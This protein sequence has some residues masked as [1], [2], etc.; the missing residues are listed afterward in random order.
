MHKSAAF[1]AFE[2][3]FPYTIP[4]FAGFWFV[5]ISYGVYMHS[6]GFSFIYPTLMAAIIYGGSLEFVTVS[7]LLSSFAPL[8]TALIAFIIQARHLFYGLS[9]LE[10]YRGTGRK[11]PFLLFWLSDE[12]FA[13]NYSARIPKD[14][15]RS[16]FYLWISLLLYIYWVSGAFLGGLLSNLI[17]FN[18]NG[19][20]FV[21]VT[22]FIVIFL[23]H[24][25]NERS[26]LSSYMGLFVSA[27]CL[28]IFGA[29]SF[30]IPTMIALV[31]LLTIFRKQ[32]EKRY[33]K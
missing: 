32:I 15:D 4:L 19:L 12:A 20:S 11:K 5:G 21:I 6:M 18:T 10:K 14:V 16:W 13:L 24:M 7:M 33:E 2:E 28:V 25:I 27:I 17:T 30:T 29:D 31:A 1:T 26:K 23:N 3:A 8:E 22:L 9:L